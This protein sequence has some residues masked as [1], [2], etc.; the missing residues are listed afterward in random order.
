MSG[1]GTYVLAHNPADLVGR[2]SCEEGEQ[3][4]GFVKV[5][6]GQRNGHVAIIGEWVKLLRGEPSTIS[7]TGRD[8]RCTVEVAE[9]AYQSVAQERVVHLPIVPVEWQYEEGAA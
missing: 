9:A 7:T 1:R 4:D 8:C 3:Q 5:K 6:T 2:V